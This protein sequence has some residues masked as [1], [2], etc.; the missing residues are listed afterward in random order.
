MLIVFLNTVYLCKVSCNFIQSY[1]IKRKSKWDTP[2]GVVEFDEHGSSLEAAS[3]AA[4]KIN[5][6]LI[7][8]GKLKLPTLTVPAAQQPPK[9]KINVSTI[10]NNCEACDLLQLCYRSSFALYMYI[11]KG[12]STKK[13]PRPKKLKSNSGINFKVARKSDS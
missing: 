8:K 7:A 1:R 2:T 12:N 5:A 11:H 13:P 3:A 10:L 6:M 9:Q 4:A